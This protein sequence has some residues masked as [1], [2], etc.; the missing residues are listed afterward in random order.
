V[1]REQ[2]NARNVLSRQGK[3]ALRA[4]GVT[5]CEV[6]AWPSYEGF[7]CL[8][9]LAHVIPSKFHAEFDTVH[10]HDNVMLLCPNHAKIADHISG[11]HEKNNSFSEYRGPR[12][13]SEM[14]A[15]LR[16]IDADPE[17]WAS[18][19]WPNYQDLH[20]PALPDVAEVESAEDE[21]DESVSEN[22]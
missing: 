19:Y 2:K 15:N 8:L 1:I 14:M 3:K 13:R 21:R 20:V 12:T 5:K 11:V 9:T 4:K 6:C 16:A 17:S 10:S 18:Q 7:G 22:Q